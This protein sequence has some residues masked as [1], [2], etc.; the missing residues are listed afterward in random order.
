MS[1]LYHIVRFRW[2]VL[3]AWPR[4]SG[5]VPFVG[6]AILSKTI[7][8]LRCSALPFLLSLIFARSPTDAKPPGDLAGVARGVRRA[9]RPLWVYNCGPS[10][11]GLACLAGDVMHVFTA[12]LALVSAVSLLLLSRPLATWSPLAITL[13]CLKALLL[14]VLRLDKASCLNPVLRH[15]ANTSSVAWRSQALASLPN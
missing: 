4:A 14:L 1:P 10:R 11:V 7:A 2:A 5:S 12:Q 6:L 3:P 13:G 9:T 8:A 15:C